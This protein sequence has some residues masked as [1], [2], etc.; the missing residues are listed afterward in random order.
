MNPFRSVF[1]AATTVCMALIVGGC[2]TSVGTPAK[3]DSVRATPV[4]PAPAMSDL[5]DAK[6]PT[7]VGKFDVIKN[8]KQV[9]ISRTHFRSTGPFSVLVLPDGANR[10]LTLGADVQGWF[11]WHLDPGAYTLQG[12][13]IGYEKRLSILGMAG[14]F[15]IEDGDQTVYIGH[16]TVDLS[17]DSPKISFREAEQDVIQEVGKRDSQAPPPTKRLLMPEEKIGAYSHVRSTCA[18]EWGVECSRSLRG[19]EPIAPA[20]ARN[21]RGVGFAR[22]DTTMPE[23]R[24]KPAPGPDITYDVAVWEAADYTL[25][26][27]L[28]TGH[29]PGKLIA[30]KEALDSPTLALTTPLNRNT[31]YHWSVRLRK[32]ETVS[33]WSRAGHSMF[34]VVMWSYSSG[35]WFGLETPE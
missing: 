25:P 19:V 7:V 26:E 33:T 31:K 21:F 27:T 15:T 16:F 29:M 1:Q 13:A 35:Y 28:I 18:K 4:K 32:G 10:M 12:L 9:M 20:V 24:W 23:L 14:R 17:S 5:T 6:K 2:A 8:G 34:L 11:A 30:Y 22:V 3:P